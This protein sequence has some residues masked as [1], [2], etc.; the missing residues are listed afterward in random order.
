MKNA[1]TL[2]L[3]VS[4]SGLLL[5]ACVSQAPAPLVASTPVA[6][7]AGSA[8]TPAAKVTP[9]STAASSKP[10]NGAPAVTVSATRDRSTR[11]VE[12]DGVVYFCERPARTGSHFISK[13]EECYTEA[14]LRALRERDQDFVHRQQSV[15][16]QTNTTQVTKT[17]VTP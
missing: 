8:A 11:R 15:A 17:P 4:A 14:Q 16:L 13:R 2:L 7:S 10:A 5:T 1:R 3:V 9:G 12:K 6:S